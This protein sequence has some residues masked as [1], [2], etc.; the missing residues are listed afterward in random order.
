M[1]NLTRPIGYFKKEA[2]SLLKQVKLQDSGALKRITQVLKSSED[3]TLMRAQHV[4]A[5]EHGFSKWEDLTR[6]SSVE[7]HLAITLNKIPQLN[8]FGI[9][10]FGSNRN[11]PKAE[12]DA[13]FEKNRKVLRKSVEPVTETINWLQLNIKPIKSLNSNRS[14]YGIK[15]IAEKDLGYI[16]NGVFIAA[17]IIAGYPY[18]IV[19]DSPNVSFGMSE[20]S[21]KEINRNHQGLNKRRR[22]PLGNLLRGPE[23]VSTSPH[24]AAQAEKFDEMTLEEQRHYLDEDARA[25]GLFQR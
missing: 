19:F 15:H 25:M 10:S 1:T 18:K 16:T 8:D 23:V 7:L 22:T 6:S 17:A 21:F 3:I 2:K 12:R 4:V 5:V 14:S 11:L 9:G 13:I 24:L 20:K